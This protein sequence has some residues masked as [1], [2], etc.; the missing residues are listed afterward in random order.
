MVEHTLSFSAFF[1][2]L[3]LVNLVGTVMDIALNFDNK[4]FDIGVGQDDIDH[5]LGLRTAVM[6]SLFTDARARDDDEI[7]DGTNDK[8]GHWGD[9]YED[10]IVGSRLWLLERAK[11]TQD[12]LDRGKQYATEALGWFI[13]DDIASKINV[14]TYWLRSGVM[15]MVITM[16]MLDGSSYEELFEYELEAA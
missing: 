11:E 7:P 12:T 5:D 3:G 6:I 2:L 13:E 14:E 15:A 16:T 1:E 4:Q 8:R 9:A 10:D